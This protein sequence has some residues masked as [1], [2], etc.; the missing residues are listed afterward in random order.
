[1]E[2]AESTKPAATPVTPTRRGR[3]WSVYLF[4]AVVLLVGAP[5]LLY[6]GL[7][8]HSA[9]QAESIMAELDR[10]DPHWRLDDLEA[11]RE[12]LDDDNNSALLVT[13]IVRMGGGGRTSRPAFYEQFEDV[14]PAHELNALQIQ[15]LRD[16]YEKME[17]A[18]AE[19][20]KL[21]DM[22]K[23]RFPIRYAEDFFSTILADQQNA[24]RVFEMLQHDAWMRAQN[25]D[26]D[27]A[28]ESC[29]AG[30]NAAR[31][32]GDEP[33]LISFLIRVAGAH[34]ALGAVERTLAQGR[35]SEKALAP[36]QTLIEQEIVD[37][38]KH[39]RNALRGERGGQDKLMQ[40]IRG[41]KVRVGQ[42][43]GVWGGGPGGPVEALADH[44]PVILTR[45]APDLLRYMNQAVEITKLPTE[46]QPDKLL[47]LERTIPK[48]S[49]LMRL[50]APA[51][52]KVGSAHVRAQTL[53]RAAQVGIAAERYRLKHERWPD[54]IDD[55]VKAG[56][57]AAVPS[58]PFD[59]APLR[60][61]R[62]PEGM[63]AYSVGI[64]KADNHGNI[65]MRRIYDRGFDIGFRL[66]DVERRRQAPRP[67]VALK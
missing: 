67:P 9:N 43:F 66:W 52:N 24:R 26:L 19:A 49:Y 41:G 54:S 61:R 5:T 45:E 39:W 10:V 15:L 51:L 30:L 22:P 48:A 38:E 6:Q 46:E 14:G 62:M 42:I 34:V 56:L 21:K 31:S 11:Q 44:F 23:G 2:S 59:G 20:R 63:A 32:L 3:R 16:A 58:D 64:D 4:A 1:M 55:L 25:G 17:D 27:G 7:K 33:L 47:E 35:P 57:I 8:W 50:L 65:N 36:L 28:V 13:K 37:V 53:L 40:A 60:W 29:R 18:L 12:T